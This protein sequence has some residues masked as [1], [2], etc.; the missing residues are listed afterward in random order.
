MV[1]NG[2]GRASMTYA[3]GG[4]FTVTD[5]VVYTVQMRF[6]RWWSRLWGVN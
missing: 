1:L 4:Y 2:I 5:G 6:L 3:P